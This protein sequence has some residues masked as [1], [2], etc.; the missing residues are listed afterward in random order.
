MESMEPQDV[1]QSVGA[2]KDKTIDLS[3]A[4]KDY[5]LAVGLDHQLLL[6]QLRKVFAARKRSE[7]AAPTDNVICPHPYHGATLDPKQMETPGSFLWESPVEEEV[8]PEAPRI[9]AYA[10]LEFEDGEFYMNT[11]SL[12]LGRDLEAARLA[13]EKVP[14]ESQS[15]SLRRRRRSNSLEEASTASVNIIQEDEHHMAGIVVSEIGGIIGPAAQES[16]KKQRV[17]K[18]KSTTSSS[19]QPSRKSSL[20]FRNG[21][22]PAQSLGRASSPLDTS[23]LHDPNPEACPLVRIHPPITGLAEPDSQGISRRHAMIAFNFEKNVFELTI[24]GRNGAFVDEL[25]CKAGDTVVLKN[26]SLIQIGGVHL[27]FLLPDVS[28][29]EGVE[30]S[31]SATVNGEGNIENGDPGILG[32]ALNQYGL[33]LEDS[34]CESTSVDSSG[35]KNPSEEDQSDSNADTTDSPSDES[36]DG[37]AEGGAHGKGAELDDAGEPEK[38]KKRLNPGPKQNIQSSAKAKQTKRGRPRSSPKAKSGP[39]S[40]LNDGIMSVLTAPVA[41]RRGPGRPPKNGI[42]SKREERLLAKQAQDSAEKAKSIEKPSLEEKVANGNRDHVSPPPVVPQ[43]RK[44]TK[45]KTNDLQDVIREHTGSTSPNRD[46]MAGPKA[47]KVKKAAKPPRSPSPLIDRDSLTPAQLMKPPAS[48]LVLLYDALTAGP[49]EGMTLSQIYRALSRKYHYF[50]FSVATN[51]WQSSVRHNLAQHRVFTKGQEG[52]E[53]NLWHLDQRYLSDLEKK[54]KAVSLSK[55]SPQVMPVQHNGSQLHPTQVPQIFSQAPQNYPYAQQERFQT[56]MALKTHQ[57]PEVPLSNGNLPANGPYP[58]FP[59]SR[60]NL[61]YGPSV[62]YQHGVPSPYSSMGPNSLSH[63]LLNGVADSSSSYRSPYQP[64]PP[65]GLSQPLVHQQAPV[66]SAH[67]GGGERN[68]DWRTV[69]A[70]PLTFETA[71]NPTL[72]PFPSSS[73]PPLASES[74]TQGLSSAPIPNTSQEIMQAVSRFKTFLIDSMK[75]HK[76]GEALVTSAINRVLGIQTCSSVPGKEEDPQEKTIMQI[77]SGMLEDL[78]K[79]S[80]QLGQFSRSPAQPNPSTSHVS[81]TIAPSLQVSPLPESF[82][83]GQNLRPSNQQQ[84]QQQANDGSESTKQNHPQFHHT[85]NEHH[86]NRA[87]ST[88]KLQQSNHHL[89]SNPTV[90]PKQNPSP[91]PSSS[92]SDHAA[93]SPNNNNKLLNSG[94]SSGKV[95][96]FTTAATIIAN[97]TTSLDS[98]VGVVTPLTPPGP[99]ADMI[100][101]QQIQGHQQQQQVEGIENR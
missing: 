5:A 37:D 50:K 76:H 12:V 43:K 48:Y 18:S 31:S 58:R 81:S 57:Y 14:E 63:P 55:P 22:R 68:D 69:Q 64:T 2:N 70:A 20:D 15:N 92:P 11:Y 61:P 60:N 46:S 62:S 77:F 6:E 7:S 17:N 39:S 99:E 8:D 98:A 32:R 75:E 13:L 54:G 90:N 33:R 36:E 72:V 89:D 24:R 23:A 25:S 41:K 101:G 86:Q 47:P 29:G 94:S 51:G 88:P 16:R 49:S 100:G 40:S 42:M 3:G 44:Y 91:D 79:K 74:Q 95:T 26:G 27:R 52:S 34:P 4:R 78:K 93:K 66:M 85:H 10:K 53:S 84:Q 21:L 19:P 67:S 96:S 38:R 71:N 65:S 97:S 80:S 83:A 45:R 73:T 1:Q 56:P 9:Q 28:S 82:L 30:D 59:S 35:D 87:S